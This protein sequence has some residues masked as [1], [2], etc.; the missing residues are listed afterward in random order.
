MIHE[1][2]PFVQQYGW[3]VKAGDGSM[4]EQLL[5]AGPHSDRVIFD[6]AGR[7]AE[8]WMGCHVNG[9]STVID[10]DRLIPINEYLQPSEPISYML[11]VLSV[12][13]PLSLQLH[14]D[15]VTAEY[16]HLAH[17]SVYKDSNHKPE[18]AIAISDEFH[19]LAGFRSFRFLNDIVATYPV[20][21]KVFFGSLDAEV[22]SEYSNFV[23]TALKALVVHDANSTEINELIEE[24]RHSITLNQPPSVQEA[25]DVFN[26]LVSEYPHDKSVFTAFL[27]NKYTLKRGE[28]IY[29]SPGLL[30]AYLKGDCVECMAS[31][32]NVIRGGLTEKFIDVENLLKY[33]RFEE[34]GPIRIERSLVKEGV[35]EYRP[36][37][38]DFVVECLHVNAGEKLQLSHDDFQCSGLSMCLVMDGGAT[39]S[40]AT[41]CIDL[42]KG[43]VFCLEPQFEVNLK[44]SSDVE[45]WIATRRKI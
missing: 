28:C 2:I 42:A 6:K 10:G 1:I 23:S 11:K 33:T 17:P 22:P 24:M 14:P 32:D 44:T 9:M 39:L 13:K 26:I 43:S 40:T 21:K 35:H 8:L 38:D 15:K 41:S 20:I 37:V 29:L 7:F 45:M 3:G 12:A 4:V 36:P 25:T 30:H 18:I 19:A 31:S 16:L 5:N 34:G 27:M